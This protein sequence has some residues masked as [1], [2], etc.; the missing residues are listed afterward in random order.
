M[1]QLLD[2][3]RADALHVL[4]SLKVDRAAI[5]RIG[6]REGWR[7]IHFWRGPSPEVRLFERY[8]FWVENR[9]MLELVTEDMVPRYRDLANGPAQRRFLA[10]RG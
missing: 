7:T 6:A 1:A 9:I 4:L 3:S 2:A 5:E 10:A 8:E